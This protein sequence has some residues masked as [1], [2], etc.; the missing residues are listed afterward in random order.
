VLALGNAC[1]PPPMPLDPN[2][3][4]D[5]NSGSAE[6]ASGPGLLSPAPRPRP[7]K[8]TQRAPWPHAAAAA[9]FHAVSGEGPSDHGG[10]GYRRRVRVD[11]AARGYGVLGR[12]AQFVPGAR[13]LEELRQDGDARLAA[14]FA[15]TKLAPGASPSTGDWRFEVLD[16]DLRVAVEGDL[17]AACARCHL[18][19]PHDAVFGPSGLDAPTQARP[20]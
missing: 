2:A 12:R 11:D 3:D 15:M 8:A 9:T 19:A 17:T 10:G 4:W 1:G 18:E 13:I 7:V 16:A 20:L 6:T 14:V 5:S